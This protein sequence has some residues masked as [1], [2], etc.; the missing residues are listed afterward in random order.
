MFPTGKIQ[1]ERKMEERK[2]EERSKERK[3]GRYRKESSELR[4]RV[5]LNNSANDFK[6]NNCNYERSIISA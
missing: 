2:M 3:E 5:R 1:E 6:K 4:S